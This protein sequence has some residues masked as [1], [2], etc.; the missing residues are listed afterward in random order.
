MEILVEDEFYAKAFE[1]SR[2]DVSECLVRLELDAGAD[3]LD[4]LEYGQNLKA[5]FLQTGTD[6]VSV[7]FSILSARC[8]V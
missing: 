3:T 7:F 4:D 2:V 6:L 5:G 8:S 1:L